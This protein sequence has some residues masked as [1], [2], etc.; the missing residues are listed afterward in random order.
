L[1]GGCSDPESAQ[2]S[3]ER[4]PSTS[5]PHAV[6]VDAS[7]PISTIPRRVVVRRRS[8]RASMEATWGGEARWGEGMES[9]V[10][11][12]RREERGTEK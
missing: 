8:A 4:E 1:F 7:F 5:L 9:A 10:A 2:G 3:S 12:R 11:V 6:S